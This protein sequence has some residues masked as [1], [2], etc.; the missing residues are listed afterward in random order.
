MVAQTST[1]RPCDPFQQQARQD[2]LDMAYLMDGR[3]Q[4][5]HPLYSTYTGLARTTSYE[6]LVNANP[7]TG[8]PAG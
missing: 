8:R 1:K 5:D 2:L 4:P 6:C 3:N 7:D